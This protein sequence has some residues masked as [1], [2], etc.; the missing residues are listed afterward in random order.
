MNTSIQD[1]VDF[2]WKLAWLLR[3]WATQDLLA[4]YERE[5]RPV[6]AYNVQRA[7]EPAGA[8]RATD[9]ALPWDLNGR[10][11]HYWVSIAEEKHSTVDLLGD[12]LTLFTGPSDPRW[13][14]FTGSLP[15]KPPIDMHGLD[16]GSADALD[17]PPTCALLARPDG[18]ELGRWTHFDPAAIASLKWP[19]LA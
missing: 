3:G 15:S 9:E 13:A 7:G 6:A 10:F 16:A 8:R 5:R 12:G 1:A 14:G 11:P 2:G 19:T 4:S 17:L 18:H